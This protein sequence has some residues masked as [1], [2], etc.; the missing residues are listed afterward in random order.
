MRESTLAGEGQREWKRGRERESARKQ[1]RGAEGERI[2][3]RLHTQHG[4][5]SGLKLMTVRS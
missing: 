5:Q 1:G 2:P 4:A 3:N